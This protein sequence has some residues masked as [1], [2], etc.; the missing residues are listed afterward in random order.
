MRYFQNVSSYL[1]NNNYL[2]AVKP[3][4]EI[5]LEESEISVIRQQKEKVPFVPVLTDLLNTKLVQYESERAIK[6]D[7]FDSN[8]V[9]AAQVWKDSLTAINPDRWN[10]ILTDESLTSRD[11]IAARDIKVGTDNKQ[12]RPREVAVTNSGNRAYVTLENSH[13]IAVVD[14][15]ML[16]QVDINP[17]TQ[18]MDTI[19]LPAG[20]APREL[21][22]SPDNNFV[23]IADRAIGSVYVVDINP[24]SETFH[25]LVETINL[26]GDKLRKLAISADG[27]RLFVTSHLS[28]TPGKGS[29]HVINID[30]LDRPQEEAK[31]NTRK[32]REVIGTIEAESRTEGIAATPEVDKMVFTNGGNDAK[33]FGLLTITNN[34]PTS[35][36]AETSY[37][38][39]GIG[40]AFDYLDVNDARSVVVTKDGKYAFVGGF[41]GRNLGIGVK[42]IDGPLSGSNIGI[43]KDPLTKNAKMVA[44][45]RPIPMGL[46]SDLVLNG[47]NSTSGYIEDK[48]L[49]AAYPGVGSVFAFDVEEIIDT[50]EYASANPN[51]NID[52]TKKT[53]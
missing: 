46:T 25:E 45:T 20:A 35:F 21:V 48:F 26:P 1:E 3:P 17:E 43:I 41:N 49:Y 51:P 11:L 15:L 36:E 37:S 47:G 6:I 28:K 38:K 33:G 44:A 29:I 24:S 22:I 16:R 8:L 39:V 53:D 13:S 5:I 19:A 10:D 40:S 30:P 2:I 50:I 7:P 34:D 31:P 27:R 42:S 9:L 12:D 14:T 52:Y 32:W 4:K 18:E 23:Y